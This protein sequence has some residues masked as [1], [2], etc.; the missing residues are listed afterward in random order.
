MLATG[1]PGEFLSAVLSRFQVTDSD[2]RWIT[3]TDCFA[4][5]CAWRCRGC[6]GNDG[7]AVGGAAGELGRAF[8]MVVIARCAKRSATIP[9]DCFVA[10]LSAP[11]RDDRIC[12]PGLQCGE[13]AAVDVKHLAVH[14]IGG[15]GR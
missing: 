9:Q 11:S 4:A 5:G 12:D 8:K 15:R 1:W 14:E 10:A 2:H 13:P 3:T 7:P 6:G